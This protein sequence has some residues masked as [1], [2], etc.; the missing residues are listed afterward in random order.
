MLASIIIRTL[1]ESKHLEELLNAIADQESC[2]IESEVV[3][4]DSGSTDSTL[5]IATRFGCHIVN[6]DRKNFSFGR[7]LNYG[8]GVASG[9]ILVFISGHCVPTD[10][11]WLKNICRPLVM[12]DV[13]YIYGK[14]LGGINSY[15]SEQRIF[16]KY[17]RDQSEIPQ[18]DFY[19]NN[20]NSALLRTTWERFRFNEELTGLEDMDLA[21]RLLAAGG[22]VGYVAEAAVFH[23]HH[24]TWERIIHRFEREALALR[25]IMPEIHIRKRD[26]FRYLTSSI[27]LDC[28]CAYRCGEL[29][30]N[31]LS[32]FQYR[33]CQYFGSY[34][35]NSEHRKLSRL[36]KERYFYPR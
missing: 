13:D 36:N 33:F 34:R 19:C 11:L 26:F 1:N 8:C 27:W 21:K 29:H 20:A 12:R 35:G 5:S 17:F 28:V 22:R 25:T 14:Q 18:E 4:V 30:R 16:A 7:S 15:F 24:E 6:I 23:L 32:I 3:I 9:N 10:R 31:L 2:G